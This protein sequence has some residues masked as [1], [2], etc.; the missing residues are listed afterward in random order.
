MRNISDYVINLKQD[1]I[2]YIKTRMTWNLLLFIQL[3]Y[4]FLLNRQ[5]ALMEVIVVIQLTTA[6]VKFLVIYRQ[7]GFV[8]DSISKDIQSNAIDYNVSKEILLLIS[9]YYTKGC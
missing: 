6:S 9:Q 7:M 5:D 3:Y 2:Q 8:N 4:Q 1:I